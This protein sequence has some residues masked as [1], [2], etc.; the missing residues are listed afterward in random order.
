MKRIFIVMLIFICL[1][2]VCCEKKS[3]EEN[4]EIDK[5]NENPIEVNEEELLEKTINAYFGKYKSDTYE[6][7][8]LYVRDVKTYGVNNN[9]FYVYF[10]DMT[11]VALDYILEYSLGDFVFKHP[12]DSQICVYKI[13]TN[14]V[15]LLKEAYNEGILK[16][17]DIV[18]LFI[19]YYEID[20][21]YYHIR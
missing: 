5:D 6:S 2:F 14:E 19:K 13:D 15:Y 20:N 3:V 10:C 21:D 16:R 9:L 8:N 12:D 17:E 7:L 4:T 18:Y 1:I 11:I